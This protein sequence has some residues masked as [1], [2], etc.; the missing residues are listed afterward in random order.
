MANKTRKIA[1]SF[2]NTSYENKPIERWG[3]DALKR[4]TIKSV[5]ATI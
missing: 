1:K 5:P 2:R 4:E 3:I